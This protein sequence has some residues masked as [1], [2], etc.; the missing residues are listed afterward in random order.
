VS[1]D[2]KKIA[3][4]DKRLNRWY[5]EIEKGTPVKIS[6]ERFEDREDFRPGSGLPTASG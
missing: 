5:V 6:T 3:Y 4:N 1:P 2:S